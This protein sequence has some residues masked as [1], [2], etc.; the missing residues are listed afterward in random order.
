MKVEIVK[1]DHFGRGITYINGKICFV[2]KALP[3]EIVKVKIVSETKKY[4]I[5]RVLDYYKI[6]DSRTEDR[7]MY[8]DVCG[9][10]DLEHLKLEEEKHF[11]CEKVK[12]ILRKFGGVSD[13][14]VRDTVC[15]NEYGYRNKVT[16]HGDNGDLGYYEKN[17]N[18]IV[19]I[20]K[21]LLADEKINKVITVLNEM[22]FTSDIKEAVIRVS[23]DSS[24]VMVSLKGVV[25]D[26]SPLRNMVDVLIIN[27]EVML[28]EGSII[29]SIGNKKYYVSDKS[30][31]Q[32]NKELTKALYDEVRAVVAEE[33][34]KKVLDLYCG[35]GTIGI[36]ISDL[37]SEVVGIDYSKEG[38]KDAKRNV[39]LNDVCNAD[40]ICEKV[41]NVIENF[42]DIDMIIVDPP[43]AGLDTKTLENI[44]RIG[45]KTVVYVSCDPVT[46]G[47]DL[48]VLGTDY[49]VIEV[50]PYNMF[51]RTYHVECVSILYRKNLGK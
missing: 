32:V 5:G 2:E 43:R 8:A 22:K 19:S 13:I 35:T 10:C 25:D 39:V 14:L 7:C 30:F 18:S 3:G 23:N 42:N 51:P 36:Y 34:P 28:G 44:K 24:E 45:A 40:F 29:S 26:Y 21:C 11:K 16:L 47:R 41:E 9:G 38:I 12:E 17:S 49:E 1:L 37:V 4:L 33:E 6:S 50:K 15:V 27:D 46:L 31:F 20:D 48:K